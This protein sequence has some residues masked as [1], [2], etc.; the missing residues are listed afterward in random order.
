MHDE[1][2]LTWREIGAVLKRDPGNMSRASRRFLSTLNDE[3]D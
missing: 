2:H 1:H 3:S